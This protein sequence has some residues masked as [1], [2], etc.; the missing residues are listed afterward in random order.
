[1]DDTVTI[2]DRRNDGWKNYLLA[3]AMTSKPNE[4]QADEYYLQGGNDFEEFLQN[5]IEGYISIC[6]HSNPSGSQIWKNGIGNV[7]LCD[8]GCGYR[9][10]KLGCLC[11]ETGEE[12]YVYVKNQKM[13]EIWR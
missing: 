3:H 9:S 6:G 11:I 1:M 4:I 2:A 8:C 13:I 12:M 5:G 7:I 10:G